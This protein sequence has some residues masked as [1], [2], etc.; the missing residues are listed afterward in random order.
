MSRRPPGSLARNS[1]PE[2]HGRLLPWPQRFWSILIPSKLKVLQKTTSRQSVSQPRDEALDSFQVLLEIIPRRQF[3]E[4]ILDQ[5]QLADPFHVRGL[6]E[7]A[8]L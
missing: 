2:E 7:H 4:T 5:L 1:G 3:L 8:H 6:I